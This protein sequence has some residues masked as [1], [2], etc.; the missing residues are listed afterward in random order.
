MRYSLYFILLIFQQFTIIS[1]LTVEVYKKRPGWSDSYNL[2]DKPEPVC[3]SGPISCFKSTNLWREVPW[4]I[5][6]SQFTS[7]VN[8]RDGINT[9][10]VCLSFMFVSRRI[11]FTSRS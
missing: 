7:V 3:C 2:R 10:S 8:Q 4:F 11:T 5:I 9:G 1:T 6:L